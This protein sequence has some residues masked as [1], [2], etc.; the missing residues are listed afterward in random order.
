LSEWDSYI[1]GLYEIGLGEILEIYQAGY[2]VFKEKF[3]L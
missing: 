1:E 2:E 3:G